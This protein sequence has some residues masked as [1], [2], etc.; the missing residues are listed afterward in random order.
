MAMKSIT[1]G[2]QSFI[3]FLYSIADTKLLSDSAWP[4]TFLTQLQT[5]QLRS[6]AL[7]RMRLY[8]DYQLKTSYMLVG[9]SNV[10]R[11]SKPA[12]WMYEK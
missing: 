2:K 3:L 1:K 5:P 9:R 12:D 8:V 10:L 11:I 6:V 4:N 7:Y